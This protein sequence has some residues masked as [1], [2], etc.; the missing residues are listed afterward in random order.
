MSPAKGEVCHGPR[1]YIPHLCPQL[2]AHSLESRKHSKIGLLLNHLKFFELRGAREGYGGEVTGGGASSPKRLNRSPPHL[3]LILVSPEQKDSH[4]ESFSWA[5]GS[6][7]PL[8]ML[9]LVALLLGASL[10]DAHAGEGRG[11]VTGGGDAGQGGLGAPAPHVI[12]TPP[13]FLQGCERLAA[14]GF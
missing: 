1:T 10:Q 11:E 6:M 3:V 12:P 8:K 9:L 14:A 5:P 4:T 2:S 13:S 7:T